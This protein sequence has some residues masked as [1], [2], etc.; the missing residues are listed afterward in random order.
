[1]LTEVETPFI[2]GQHLVDGGLRPFLSY[3][4][5][6]QGG[7]MYDE[8]NSLG[9]I[10]HGYFLYHGLLTRVNLTYI[11]LLNDS[12][13]DYTNQGW[14]IANGTDYGPKGHWMF[15]LP[16]LIFNSTGTHIV[17]VDQIRKYARMLFEEESQ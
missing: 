9:G 6:L 10:V 1:M 14:Y 2:R 16:F 5:T 11:Y 17:T 7:M 8:G 4:D 3:L 12:G 13:T 15:R